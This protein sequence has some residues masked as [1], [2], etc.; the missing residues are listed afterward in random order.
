METIQLNEFKIIGI[1]VRTNN[2]DLNKLTSD[3]QGLW[4]RF[5]AEGVMQKIPNRIDDEICCIYTDY[6]GDHTK[7]Y[8]A[9]LG[10]RVSTLDEIPDGLSGRHYAGGKY[11]KKVYTGNILAGAVYAAW[12][13][14]WSLN[15]ERSY[16]AD[17]EIYGA[18]A[19]NPENAE[20]EI[21]IGV[22]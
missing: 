2:S 12:K 3:M 14:I 8:T 5:I 10:C 6:E 18:K 13:E 17:L 4:G 20:F 16:V 11:A 15:L 9:L 22:K 19:A 21:M 1:K 7:P